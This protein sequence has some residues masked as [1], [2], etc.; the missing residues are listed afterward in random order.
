MGFFFLRKDLTTTAYLSEIGQSP[1]R[2]YGWFRK[3]QGLRNFNFG[4]GRVC[5][6]SVF[7]SQLVE[8]L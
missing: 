4:F 7:N 6:F 2:E 5:G 8:F 1:Q 3:W